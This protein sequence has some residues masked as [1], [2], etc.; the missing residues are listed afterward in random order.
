MKNKFLLIGV[1]IF[2]FAVSA[3]AVNGSNN[4]EIG[5]Q[6]Q[7]QAQT[8][9]QGETS[10]AQVA[11]AVQEMLQV[12]ERNEEFGQQIKT[13]AQNHNQNQE[14]IEASLQKTQGRGGF[15]KFF[16]GPNYNE[17]NNI[18]EILDINEEQV[19]QLNQIKNQLIN[20]ADQQQLKEQVRV[21][22]QANLEVESS[23]E[24]EKKGFSLFGWMF[25]LF[26]R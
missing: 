8:A 5:N 13:I 25:R 20:Q 7:Q 22:E 23:L 17:I 18:K 9:N 1:F 14:K 11:N 10:R 16:V 15:V 19:N 2:A 4:P 24:V 3:Y 26:A 21:L 12:A 6:A